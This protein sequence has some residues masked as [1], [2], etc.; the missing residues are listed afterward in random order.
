M[1][2][3]IRVARSALGA[4]VCCAALAACAAPDLGPRPQ[5]RAPSS[6][7]SAL[8][9][10]NRTT[11]GA[12]AW[13]ADTWW[14]SFGDPQLD[15]LV[16]EALANSPDVARAE[17]RIRQA[18]GAAL[19]AGAQTLPS[20]GVDGSAGFTKQS[21]NTGAPSAFIPH[22]WISTGSLA[23]TGDFDLDLWG[24]NRKTLAAATSEETA[25]Q[26]DARQARVMLST[27]VVSTYFDLARLAARGEVLRNELA[28]RGQLA[29]LATARVRQGLDNN[30]SQ[31]QAEALEAQARNA[32]A[33]ND[34]QLL[35]T[36][37]AL[38][39]LLGAGPDRGL[40]IT[41]APIARFEATPVPADAGI[42]LAG[43]RP[44]IVAARLRVEAAGSRI[45]AAK[46]AF[47]PDISLSGLIGLDALHIADMFKSGSTYGNAGAAISLPIFQGGRL[48][49]QFT[50]AR[51]AYDLAVADYDA[52]VIGALQDVAD[53]LS[54]RDAAA[55]RERD[56]E[57]AA[58]RYEAAS[59]LALK[60]YNAGLSTY[61]DALQAQTGA[62]DARTA[63][64]DAR[65]VTLAYDIAL[66]RALG[67]GY[68]ENSNEGVN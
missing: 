33:A 20:I 66:R 21:Y 38:A 61:I 58:Q 62:L 52:T 12:P 43:R 26:V 41:P 34:A 59:D 8:S 5:T 56:A 42:A 63:A 19:I 14:R 48:T 17:A 36:R 40:S 2:S 45:D 67:G 24:R 25:A 10:A 23:L 15:T 37:H 65:F 32:L 51:G 39:A 54:N 29:R 44:D 60:R 50:Q 13:P 53:A 3:K 18:R 46:A 35:V 7:Q 30:T 11:V 4:A 16:A 22:G 68:A 1:K 31:L 47:L 57:L 55:L 64:V 6:Q 27:N 49:G 28:A 9:L